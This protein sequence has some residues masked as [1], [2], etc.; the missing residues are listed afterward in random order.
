MVF[1]KG[2]ENEEGEKMSRIRKFVNV[3]CGDSV[4]IFG[5]TFQKRLWVL[6]KQFLTLRGKKIHTDVNRG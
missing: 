1:Q 2:K 5:F 3:Q 6:L 4:N